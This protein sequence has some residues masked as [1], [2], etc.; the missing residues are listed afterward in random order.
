MSQTQT[1]NTK[2]SRTDR[3]NTDPFAGIRIA[4]QDLHSAISDA[5]TQRGQVIKDRLQAIAPTVSPLIASIKTVIGAQTE[6]AKKHLAEAIEKFEGAEAQIAVT[7]KTTGQ[8]FHIALQQA[9]ADSRSAV[10]KISE[11]VAATRSA[12]ATPK[13]KA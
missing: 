9:L 13:T 2:P 11:V 1:A 7:L 4:A 6:I 8:A 12:R 10:Q 5:A 3:T